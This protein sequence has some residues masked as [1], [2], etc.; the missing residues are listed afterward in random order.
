SYGRACDL[1]SAAGCIG[2]AGYEIDDARAA[3][4]YLRACKIGRS[5]GCRA[6]SALAGKGAPRCTSKARA[7]C[8][9]NL[10]RIRARGAKAPTVDA[11]ARLNR[12]CRAGVFRAC[13]LRGRL[14]ARGAL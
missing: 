11:S 6:L 2:A 5:A 13:Q 7:A 10:S 4:L 9:A 8:A 12:A 14:I 3:E 1:E